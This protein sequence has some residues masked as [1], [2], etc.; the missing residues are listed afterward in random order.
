MKSD[1]LRYK[2]VKQESER[3]QNVKE[4]QIGRFY[5]HLSQRFYT[6]KKIIK[7]LATAYQW[8]KTEIIK[9]CKPSKI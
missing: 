1:R 7:K 2:S 3:C 8:P 5:Y 6:K 9:L 4:K